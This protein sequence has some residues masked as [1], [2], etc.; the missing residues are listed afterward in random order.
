ASG[1]SRTLARL[2]S[3][4]PEPVRYGR[5]TPDGLAHAEYLQLANAQAC[6]LA[7]REGQ[8]DLI[9]NH[10]GIEGMVL[11]AS[12]ET[13]VISTMHNPFV[14]RTQPIWDAYPWY[15][16]AVSAASAATFPARG[17]LPPILHGIDVSAFVPDVRPHDVNDADGYLCFLGRF[18]PA[19]G[20][21]RAIQAALLAGR[22]L[23]LAGKI[24]P[25]DTAH[26]RA[27]V[28]PWLDGDQIRTVG[29]VG[30]ETKRALLANADALLFPIEWQEPFGL[31]MVEALATGTP[32]IG[33]RRASVPEVIRDGVTGFVVDD[34]DE[35]A[36][37]IGR[38]GEIDRATCRREA[39]TRFS[40]RRM[41]DDVEAMYRD[42]L[43]RGSSPTARGSSD[44]S[45][46][47][48][49]ERPLRDLREGDPHP[50]TA[51]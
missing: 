35:M 49:P 20:A 36:A 11:A 12:S 37:A 18:T 48:R 21:D 43:D 2:R 13:P 28:E 17:A 38:L 1:D 46:S 10:A 45:A 51:R 3:V 16:H 40:V 47:S 50:T 7:A 41:V 34:V 32:V 15:H 27:A 25:A 31:V 29:E 9:H 39:E 19:K 42:V 24:D 26:V 30:G 8:F 14:P 4:T 5:T 23:V 33:F 44:R 22:R 6:F